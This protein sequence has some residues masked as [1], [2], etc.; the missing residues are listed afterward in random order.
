MTAEIIQLPEQKEPE[1]EQIELVEAD[2]KLRDGTLTIKQKRKREKKA[3]AVKAKSS[4]ERQKSFVE[5]K[6]AA[7]FKKDWIHA[8]VIALAE[9]AG[10]Q[11]KITEMLTAQR[12]VQ[13]DLIEQQRAEIAELKVQ[14]A[15][16]HSRVSVI[17]TAFEKQ[18]ADHAVEIDR[19]NTREVDARQAWNETESELAEL[20]RK[21]KRIP[22]WIHRLFR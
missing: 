1:I 17:E 21:M 11:E 20:Q 16:A 18:A 9:E 12:A 2:L 10:G 4:N 19:A 13:R 15:D 8:D 22:R 14:L 3:D 6:K 5:A 7:G